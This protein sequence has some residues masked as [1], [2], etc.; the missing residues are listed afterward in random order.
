[1]IKR[2]LLGLLAGLLLLAGVLVVNT[3]RQGSRQVTVPALAPM[4]APTPLTEAATLTV[5][6]GEPGVSP[7]PAPLTAQTPLTVPTVASIDA[8]PPLTVQAPLTVPVVCVG[9]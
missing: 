8:P 4:A 1:M 7:E 9:P 2:V 6:V 5:P 3:L